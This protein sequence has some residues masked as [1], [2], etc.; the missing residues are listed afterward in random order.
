VKDRTHAAPAATETDRLWGII[1]TIMT[2]RDAYAADRDRLAGELRALRSGEGEVPLLPAP[3]LAATFTR[4]F[5]HCNH[6]ERIALFEAML[7][8]FA[9]YM[10]ANGLFA[11]AAHEI[12]AGAGLTV[13]PLHYYSP[14]AT[15]AEIEANVGRT[16]STP[17]AAE[18]FDHAA[19]L[20][21]L[22]A[23]LPHA[24]ELHDVP[25]AP[26]AEGGFHWTNGM[27]GPQ[28]AFTYYA[29][30][31]QY[32]PA[33]VLEVGA[34]FS[35]LVAA[36]AAAMN[37]AT[38]V[39]CIEPYPTDTHNRHLRAEAGFRLI[40]TPVQQ[41]PLELFTSLAANDILFI[42]SSHVAKPGSDVEFLF[43]EVLPRIAPDVLV[44]VHDI[45][46]PRGYTNHYYIEQ[47]RHWNENY[48]L[49]ALLL[50]NP[51]WQVEIANAFVAGF[52]QG[53]ALDAVV[54]ALA[55]GNADKH[56]ALFPAAGGGSL[57]LRRLAG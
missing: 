18:K 51:R 25:M 16:L 37:G 20:A 53:P 17:L 8:A 46:L 11:R 22:Q 55:G 47:D 36:R 19:Q 38:Q 54:A 5:P 7:P 52:G 23:L 2:E 24:T 21:R 32:R 29:L 3:A 14:V 4:A 31:R 33:R 6:E 42:D 35:T 27:F 41:V 34:G 10:N 45:F 30:I 13:M 39:T 15:R 48:L 44:H 12:A 9:A 28:D 43:F 49:G 57:W 40:E 56:A 26:P 1:R 50:E